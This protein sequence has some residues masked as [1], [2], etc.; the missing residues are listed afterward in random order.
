MRSR[1]CGY[2]V[3]GPGAKDFPEIQ[4]LKNISGNCERLARYEYRVA[5]FEARKRVGYTCKDVKYT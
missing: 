5:D 1:Q 4:N 2:I 3:T